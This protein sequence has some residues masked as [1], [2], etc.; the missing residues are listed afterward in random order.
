MGDLQAGAAM[1]VLKPKLGTDLVGY[2][3][4]QET[5]GIHDP[6]HARA[7]VLEDGHNLVA[8]CSIEVCFF[9]S[10]DVS[11][12][13]SLIA[14]MTPIPPENIFFFATHTHAAP[15]FYETENWEHPPTESAMDAVVAAY[16]SRQPARIGI[17][18]GQLQ[19]YSINRR[20]MN[21]PVDP[22]IG[23]I[24]V[25]TEDGKPLALMGNYGNHAVVMGY[26]NQYVS[27]DWP[28]YSSTRLE[29]EFGGNFVA[30]FSQGGA[31][32]VNPLT[33]TV[34]QRLVAGHPVEAIGSTSTMYGSYDENDSH[35]WNIGDRGGGTF[36]EAE[37]IALAYN[38]EVMRVWRTI[39]TNTVATLWTKT[40]MVNGAPSDDEEPILDDAPRRVMRER[41]E[42][43]LADAL[44]N[45]LKMEVMLVG[46]GKAVLVGH[47]GE[48]FSE[49]AVKLRKL[50]QQMG[51]TYP[52]LIS[53]ANGWLSYLTPANAYVEGGYEVGVSQSVGLS[54]FIQD[55]ILEAILPHLQAHVAK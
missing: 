6:I 26:D 1:I 44:E 49:D 37:T 20:F 47:P 36:T 24:R 4:K 10:Q 9:T 15:A 38:T 50:C 3:E 21:R 28:G 13:R 16:A 40:I 43:I 25:D 33:E 32:D 29:T 42:R 39:E 19:G 27:G 55:R 12:M 30:L 31:G 34:R 46:I 2:A 22:S 5:L 45:Q 53:Y 11:Q 18:F 14:N 54:R 17:G 48:T 23:I 8:L 35:S 52:M 51:I 41:F 7:L